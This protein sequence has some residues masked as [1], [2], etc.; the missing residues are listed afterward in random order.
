MTKNATQFKKQ[1]GRKPNNQKPASRQSFKALQDKI[2]DLEQENTY[3]RNQYATEHQLRTELDEVVEDER[4]LR[5]DIIKSRDSLKDTYVKE[6][7]QLK[8]TNACLL[9]GF[10]MLSIT[11]FL[12]VIGLCYAIHKFNL[13]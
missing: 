3:L 5:E 13:S 7:F 4:K 11:C 9:V 10:V 1:G 8:K 12:A 6:T 2:A